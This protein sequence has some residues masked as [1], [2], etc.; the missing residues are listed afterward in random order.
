VPAYGFDEHQRNLLP[1]GRA[2]AMGGAYT[3]IANDPSGTV[4]NPAGLAFA[5]ESENSLSVNSYNKATLIYHKTIGTQ[6]YRTESQAIFPAFIGGLYKYDR[7]T[8]AWS[9]LTRDAKSINQNDQFKNLQIPG[10]TLTDFTI[11]H[12]EI[13]NLTW[14]GGSLAIAPTQHFSIGISTFYYYH[15]MKFIEHQN[16]AFRGGN[17]TLSN[18]RATATNNGLVTMLGS[19]IKG[20]N[21]TFGLAAEI[22][23]ALTDNGRVYKSVTL[24]V[25]GEPTQSIPAKEEETNEYDDFTPSTI[26]LGLAR[27]F[28]SS[29]IVSADVL[30][31]FWGNWQNNHEVQPSLIET[32][33][34]SLGAELMLRPL[35]LRCGMFS[36]NSLT[37]LINPEFMNQANHINYLGYTAGIGYQKR[38]L[39][40]DLI[41]N[42][43]TGSGHGQIIADSSDIQQVKGVIEN[44]SLTI[45]YT[46]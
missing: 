12:L 44:L 9:Y 40:I 6:D 33:N 11:Q 29:F 19:Q 32:T 41:A 38:G 42:R 15:D 43:Q 24:S 28:G 39:G 30:H 14:G 13:N 31:H 22:P 16:I 18:I 2:A 4:Y 5:Q 46:D 37:P 21:W 36:N 10:S 27:K 23:R 3:A 1:G 45:T 34:Y 35:F 26:R 7:T 25:P 17:F 8:L 20:D